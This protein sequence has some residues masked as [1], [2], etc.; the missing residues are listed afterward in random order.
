[1]TK[2]IQINSLVHQNLQELLKKI[3]HFNLYNVICNSPSASTSLTLTSS[4]TSFPRTFQI[5]FCCSLITEIQ[6]KYR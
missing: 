3:Y 1:M 2:K 6:L 5:I 4:S